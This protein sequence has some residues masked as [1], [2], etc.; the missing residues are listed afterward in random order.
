MI[1]NEI[2]GNFGKYQLFICIIVFINKF[3]VALHQM[4]IIFL[5]PPVEFNCPDKNS[6]CCD[7]PIY[8]K[9]K[10]SRTIVMEWDLICDKIWLKQ[11]SEMLFQFG[12]L[13]G[14]LIFGIASDK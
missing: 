14:S 4:A 11:T 3:G 8:N 7:N 1:L 2:I 10:F 13:L 5:A 12:I 9:T 6:S